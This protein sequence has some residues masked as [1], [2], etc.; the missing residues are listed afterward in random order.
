MLQQYFRIQADIDRFYAATQTGNMFEAQIL[1]QQLATE[2][3][4]YLELHQ[5]GVVTSYDLT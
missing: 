1:Q 2:F 5:V 4:A 3:P